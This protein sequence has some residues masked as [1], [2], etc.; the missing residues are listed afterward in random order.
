MEPILM[1]Q[2]L[3]RILKLFR[4]LYGCLPIAE[5]SNNPELTKKIELFE[6]QIKKLNRIICNEPVKIN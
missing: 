2:E 3:D 4:E 1:K 5:L 6:S